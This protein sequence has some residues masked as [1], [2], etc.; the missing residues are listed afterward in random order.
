VCVFACVFVSVTR[1]GRCVY[2]GVCVCFH[3]GTCAYV[4]HLN[5]GDDL[6]IYVREYSVTVCGTC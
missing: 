1:A 4:Y 6:Y 2:M 5:A 3:G